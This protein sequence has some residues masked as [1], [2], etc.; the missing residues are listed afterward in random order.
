SFRGTSLEPSLQQGFF[1]MQ[2]TL[3]G[4]QFPNGKVEPFSANPEV[5]LHPVDR[6]EYLGVIFR[7]TDLPPAH[8]RLVR[9]V[10]SCDVVPLKRVAG[11]IFLTVPPLSETSVTQAEYAF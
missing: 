7:V 10:N 4:K 6:V 5:H 11:E 2:N 9:I 8:P 3:K 1:H